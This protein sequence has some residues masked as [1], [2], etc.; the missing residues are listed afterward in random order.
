MCAC[1]CVCVYK[2]V[3]ALN[4]LKGLICLKFQLTSSLAVFLHSF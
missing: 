1:V 4:N 3:L 2:E